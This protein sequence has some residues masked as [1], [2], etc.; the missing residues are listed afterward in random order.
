MIVND[1]ALEKC[2]V[3]ERTYDDDFIGLDVCF[4]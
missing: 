4:N 2:V 1:A 3:Q